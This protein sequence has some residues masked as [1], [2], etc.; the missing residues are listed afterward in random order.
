MNAK[1]SVDF[2]LLCLRVLEW[3]LIE[4]SFESAGVQ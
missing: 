2:C 4:V 3:L 1:W